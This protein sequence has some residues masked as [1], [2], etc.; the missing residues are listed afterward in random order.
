MKN[1]CPV[2]LAAS[3]LL[4][5]S[6]AVDSASA[7]VMI[8]AYVPGDG[9]SRANITAFNDAV[10]VDAAFINIFSG[11]VHNW[12]LLRHQSD[13]IAAENAVPMIT[14]MPIDSNR[15]SDNL[16]PEIAAGQWDDYIDQWADGLLNWV[17]AGPSDSATGLPSRRILLRF[18]HEFNGNWYAYSGDPDTYRTA[19]QRVHQRFEARG[20]NPHVEWVWCINNVSFDGIDNVAAYYP[21]DTYVDWTSIDGY[22]WGSNYTW[23]SW[24]SFTDVFA[25]SYR[26]LTEQFPN[27]PVLIG[28]VGSAEPTDATPDGDDSQQS[29][30]VWMAE[31]MRALPN[32]FPSVR[33]LTLFNINK[34]LSWSITGADNTGLEAFNRGLRRSHYSA[35]F[36]G[37][38]DEAV[39]PIQTPGRWWR[40]FN[41]N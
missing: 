13:N 25:E 31:M 34:E 20:A 18:G 7:R 9:W 2:R 8:G 21:G 23:S 5:L 28:E 24:K 30:S 16:L 27:K 40:R 1:T 29:K 33:A 22:N 17:A 26:Q 14:W 41:R 6:L 10:A 12:Q 38:A 11:F 4:L 36:I 39:G 32:R 3:A 37:A 35:D 15:R 19:W